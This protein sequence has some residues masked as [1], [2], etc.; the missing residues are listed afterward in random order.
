M[1]ALNA[2][3]PIKDRTRLIIGDMLEACLQPKTAYPYWEADWQGD[4]ILMSFDPVAHDTVGLQRLTD[5]MTTKE[6]NAEFA[7]QKA[8]PWL[9]NGEKI[10]LGAHAPEN[11][12]I[13]PIAL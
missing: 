8:T 7:T 3:P 6:I 4:E 1:P 2:L 12:A 5:L 10:G 9:E 11:I 13:M